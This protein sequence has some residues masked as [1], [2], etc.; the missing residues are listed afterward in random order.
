M[1]AHRLRADCPHPQ[2]Y[3]IRVQDEFDHGTGMGL[4]RLID[5]RMHAFDLDKA[6]DRM[7]HVLIDLTTSTVA[8]TDWLRVLR[9][10][11][12]ATA[13]RGVGLHLIA[14]GHLSPPLTAQQCAVARAL[15]TFPDLDAALAALSGTGGPGTHGT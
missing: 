15:G 11:G 5:A 10:A 8:S 7:R 2:V 13:R 3:R 9:Y 4:L 6:K 12:D 1:N 14:G